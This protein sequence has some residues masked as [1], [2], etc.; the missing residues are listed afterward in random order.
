MLRTLRGLAL[1]VA[2]SLLLAARIPALADGPCPPGS[3]V[4]I[5]TDPAHD[6]VIRRT[7]A[8]PLPVNPDA[9]VDLIAYQI[10]RWTPAGPNDPFSGSCS[11]GGNYFRF[12]LVFRGLVNPPGKIGIPPGTDFEPFR[13]GPNPV[14]AEIQVNLDRNLNTGG[15]TEF[16]R[17]NDLYLGNVGRFGFRAYSEG[18][19]EYS[20][21]TAVCWYDVIKTQYACPPET[22]RN[23]AE[24]MCHFFEDQSGFTV[25]EVTGNGNSVFER[26]EVWDID[27]H[28]CQPI[29]DIGGGTYCP[30]SS[31]RF[32]HDTTTDTTVVSLVYA[33]NQVEAYDFSDDN[34]TSVR[35]FLWQDVVIISQYPTGQ[36]V[37]VL[38]YDWRTQDPAAY[39]SAKNWELEIMVGTSLAAAPSDGQPLVWTDQAYAL[40]EFLIPEGVPGDFNGDGTV[41]AADSALLSQFIAQYDGNPDWDCDGNPSNGSLTVPAT[42]W[43]GGFPMNFYLYDLNYDGIVNAAD[44]PLA[45][46]PLADLNADMHVDA[47]DFALF[48]LAMGGP[49][50]T[51]PPA[52][53]GLA[54]FGRAD[55]DADADVDLADFAR[56]QRDFTGGP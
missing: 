51:A 35:E 4:T 28:L 47:A 40:P 7:S 22:R 54:M 21:R 3:Y 27:P 6:N 15:P 20:F 52:D 33:L 18:G 49:K 50:V 5:Y 43:D 39:M 53:C 32:A 2:V 26:G 12:D 38:L 31:G 14:F 1:L 42:A 25:Q 48:A 46:G 13:Y 23:G 10:G 16:D 56:F 24:V 34:Q 29:Q 37:D 8:C 41:D 30:P 36:Y 9:Q 17:P 55:F 44:D 11:A 45:P 19:D